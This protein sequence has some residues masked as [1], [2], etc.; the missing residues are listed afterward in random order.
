MADLIDRLKFDKRGLKQNLIEKA[1]L[2]VSLQNLND[3][4][5]GENDKLSSQLS[6]LKKNHKESVMTKL[7]EMEELKKQ[8]KAHD[9]Q[10]ASMGQTQT[11]LQDQHKKALKDK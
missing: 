5:K 1:D 11:K 3:E 4:R 6:K 10:K 2:A 8:L 7:N 9:G